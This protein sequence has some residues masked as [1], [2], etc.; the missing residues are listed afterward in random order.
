MAVQITKDTSAT[1]RKAGD[2]LTIGRRKFLKRGAAVGASLTALYVVPKMTSVRAR[3]AYAATTPIDTTPPLL[4]LNPFGFAPNLV[5]LHLDVSGTASDPESGVTNVEVHIVGGGTDETLNTGPVD[6]AWMV[7]SYVG[8]FGPFPVT[9]T[10]TAT[11][12]AGLTTVVERTELV[13]DDGNG[14]TL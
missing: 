1:S 14:S 3:P 5:G 4:T 11:N 2:G 9:V 8:G 10:A 13:F 6:G 12:G 7:S